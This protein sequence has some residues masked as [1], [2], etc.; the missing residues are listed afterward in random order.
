MAQFAALLPYVAV[1]AVVWL[2]IIRPARRRQQELGRMQSSLEV[3][4]EV[5]LT[6]GIYA[7]VRELE[8]DVAVV[9]VA[10]GVLLRVARGAIGA[11]VVPAEPLGEPDETDPPSVTKPEES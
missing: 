3:S 2:L 1:A 7:T 11:Q 4:N 5:V 8:D 10:P 6:S 9:E